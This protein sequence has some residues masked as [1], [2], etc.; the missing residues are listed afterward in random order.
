M[1]MAFFD[2]VKKLT[3][4]VAD[5]GKEAIEITKLNSQV[6]TEKDKMKDIF[7]KI[8]EQVYAAYKNG[9]DR[10]FGDSCLM[11]QEID[12]KVDEIKAKLM[13]IK[14]SAKCP[15]CGAEVS[16]EVA[17]CPKCGGKVN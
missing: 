4:N 2:D 8:G 5:K 16:K 12:A 10:G 7:A 15:A 17:F 1:I 9:E 14:D 6:S 13:E 11:L 3:K